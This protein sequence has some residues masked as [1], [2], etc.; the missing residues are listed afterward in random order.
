MK[1]LLR[2]LFHHIYQ[3]R[4]TCS[5]QHCLHIPIEIETP[6][7]LAVGLVSF[8]SSHVNR[9]DLETLGQD[10]GIFR[11]GPGA[12]FSLRRLACLSDYVRG[13]IWVLGPNTSSTSLAISIGVDDLAFLWG[14]TLIHDSMIKT[15]KGSIVP[16]NPSQ[17]CRENEIESHFTRKIPCGGQ[18]HQKLFSPECR[19]LIGSDNFKEIQNC[20]LTVEGARDRVA[21]DL[22]IPGAYP[23]AYASDG[24]TF[25]ANSRKYATLTFGKTCKKRT[26]NAQ[27]YHC[28]PVAI[29]VYRLRITPGRQCWFGLGVYR[30]C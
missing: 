22:Q 9:F 14:P 23:K 4:T 30:Q 29:G 18:L 6:E 3:R 1:N 26:G 11:I 28:G 16:V 27:R 20:M 15:E 7:A 13:P 5:I 2:Q 17:I 21:R 12:N 19:L 24:Y 10:V 25:S 8:A